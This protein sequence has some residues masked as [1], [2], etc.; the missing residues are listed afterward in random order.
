M[1]EDY[2]AQ[3]ARF[4][5][6]LTDSLVA[7]RDIRLAAV[8]DKMNQHAQAAAAGELVKL[9]EETPQLY[10][11]E[12]VDRRLAAMAAT[13]RNAIIDRAVRVYYFGRTVVFDSDPVSKRR[14]RE[15]LEGLL[16]KTEVPASSRET[17][18]CG[19][20]REGSTAFRGVRR[21]F[22]RECQCEL[23]Q[24]EAWSVAQRFARRREE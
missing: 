1:S 15:V 6:G 23:C 4:T 21:A 14:R 9:A 18:P 2:K 8:I 12:E 19:A 24:E 13:R 10:D 11:M 17:P 16:P 3:A 20:L 22:R 5:Q 7:A